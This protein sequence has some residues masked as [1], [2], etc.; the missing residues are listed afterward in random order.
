LFGGLLASASMIALYLALVRKVFSH[1]H[2]T[3]LIGAGDVAKVCV[4]A[5]VAGIALS[6]TMAWVALRRHLKAADPKRP[7]RRRATDLPET[8]ASV[9]S[10][11]SPESAGSV[12]PGRTDVVHRVG[13]Q[14]R[15][16]AADPER[17]GHRRR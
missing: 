8:A 16:H 10:A 9:E 1:Q 13:H 3:T 11:G 17:A 14:A 5:I 7:P 4:L 12:R 6:S 15:P 2:F